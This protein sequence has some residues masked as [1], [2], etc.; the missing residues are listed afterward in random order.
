MP[1]G[2]KGEG[3]V[4][5]GGTINQR[6]GVGRPRRGT[7]GIEQRAHT[8]CRPVDVRSKQRVFGKMKQQAGKKV[9]E[10]YRVH[11]DKQASQPSQPSKGIAELS[12][13]PGS[14]V[15]ALFVP[16]RA[17]GQEQQQQ[18]QQQQAD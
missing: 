6:D 10:V 5:Q 16:A 1:G 9:H 17:A 14:R 15:L 13:G 7:V 4:S 2:K 3:P 12:T 11:P 8:F 18:Q